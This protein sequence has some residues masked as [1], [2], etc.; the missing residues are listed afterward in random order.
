MRL[1][2]QIATI[3]TGYGIF[4]ELRPQ[5]AVLEYQLAGNRKRESELN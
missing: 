5:R 2:Q 3:I 1:F 4:A